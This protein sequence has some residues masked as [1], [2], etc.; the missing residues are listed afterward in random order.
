M[1]YALCSAEGRKGSYRGFPLRE[2]GL[3][4]QDWIGRCKNF[5]IMLMKL[6]WL[7]DLPMIG[8]KFT[9][10]RS[11]LTAMSRLDRFLIS[12]R[13]MNRWNG[14]SLWCMSRN[15]SDH[16]LVMLKCGVR[17]WGPKPFKVWDRWFHFPRFRSMV[18]TECTQI[19]VEGTAAYILKESLKR[20]KYKLK[21][22]SS[23]LGSWMPYISLVV[24]LITLLLWLVSFMCRISRTHYDLVL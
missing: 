1:V 20:L 16:C 14:I 13:W 2:E 23:S 17:D 12:A 19:Q 5:R 3:W 8:R 21:Q 10:Y 24:V 15:L 11:N 18:E 6:D 4:N 22:S 7:I 9:W